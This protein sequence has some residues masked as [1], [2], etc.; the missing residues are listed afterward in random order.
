MALE[1]V[2]VGTDVVI[3]G[4]IGAADQLVQNWD[5]KREAE[6]GEKL[7]VLAQAGTYYNYG[8]PILAI[9]GTAFG[10]LRGAWATRLVTVG[11][12]LAGRKVTHQV[13]KPVAAAWRG[14]KPST[15]ERQRQRANAEAMGRGTGAAAG[16]GIEF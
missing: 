12:A 7:G 4:S 10:F 11:S 2:K 3:G 5:E 15:A 8:V 6:K 9:L 16:V 1:W 14:W 13:T